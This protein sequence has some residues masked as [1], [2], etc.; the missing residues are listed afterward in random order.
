[1]ECKIVTKFTKFLFPFRYCKKSTNLET[2]TKQNEKGIDAVP[3]ERISPSVESLR[4]EIGNLLD[5]SSSERI[6][7]CFELNKNYRTLFNLPRQPS[8]PVTFKSRPA[9]NPPYTVTVEGV[10]LYLFESEVGFAEVEF[11]YQSDK[12]EDFIECNYFISEIKSEKNVFEYELKKKETEIHTF[13]MR[14]LL[15]EVLSMVDGALDIK[16][17]R[18]P[19]FPDGKGIAYSYVV[20]DSCPQELYKTLLSLG[21][22]YK[23]S[24]KI[25]CAKDLFSDS[26]IAV[27]YE[28]SYWSASYNGAANLS[29]HT[30]DEVTDR[31]FDTQ[32]APKMRNTYFALFLHVLHQR[33]AM[34]K[35]NGEMSRLDICGNDYSAME[36]A[37]EE[38]ENYYAKVSKLK[39]KAFFSLPSEVEHV[40][41]YYKMLVKIFEVDE[42]EQSFENDLKTLTDICGTYVERIRAR[43]EKRVAIRKKK[44]GLFVSLFGTLVAIVT[45]LEAYWS[46]LEKITGKN[47][48][49]ASAPVF[50]FLAVLAAVIAIVVVDVVYSI[51][52]IKKMS[53][54]LRSEN[55]D[56]EK[57]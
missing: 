23:G 16:R 20:T 30:G 11:G 47:V 13:T 42:L 2:K 57:K 17:D 37:L 46:W 24:Y 56:N 19:S 55:G 48:P 34:M 26:H 22:N 4:R 35:F 28:N 51:K 27:Q 49:F 3:F 53:R 1:M 12:L 40:N 21:R 54:E 18:F 41:D 43:E 39:F 10:R 31:F 15:K 7:D 50:I 25:P 14:S 5:Q 38:A 52:D 6:A 33:Y 29:F 32:F 36:K 9:D 8:D 44:V 45:L